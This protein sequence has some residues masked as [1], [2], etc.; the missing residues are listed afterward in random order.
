MSQNIQGDFQI[1]ISVPLSSKHIVMD[2]SILVKKTQPRHALETKFI[3][4]S[5]LLFSKRKF[6][7]KKS[8]LE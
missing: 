7:D 6:S 1:C 8:M 3:F 5:S 4:N 2:Y